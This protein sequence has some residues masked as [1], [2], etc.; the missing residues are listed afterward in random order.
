MGKKEERRKQE[1]KESIRM[2]II[3]GV[4]ALLLIVGGII[5]YFWIKSKYNDYAD[6]KDTRTVDA[7]VLSV[8][9]HS[10][11][12]EWDTKVFY[13]KAQVAY[14]VDG[15]EYKDEKEFS[16]EVKKGDIKKIEVYQNSKGEY[17]VPTVVSETGTQLTAWIFLGVSG[18][19]VLVGIAAILIAL[20]NN[21]QKSGKGKNGNKGAGK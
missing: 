21:D 7:E 20:P 10:R 9:V 1:R 11:K 6:S 15:N 13:W 17:R 3:A 2:A 8:E 12:N 19:G 4:V 16:S 5:G 14:S 18:F